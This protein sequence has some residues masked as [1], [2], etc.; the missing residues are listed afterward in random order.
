MN[1][2]LKLFFS[3]LAFDTV[4]S[5]RSGNST[6]FNSNRDKFLGAM[7]AIGQIDPALYAECK[8][9]FNQCIVNCL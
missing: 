8:N 6:F 4:S 7:G 2:A 9:W 1:E 5:L 3:D